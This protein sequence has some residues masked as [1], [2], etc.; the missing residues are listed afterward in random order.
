MKCLGCRAK[1]AV[2]WAFVVTFAALSASRSDAATF[3]IQPLD[4]SGFNTTTATIS[5]SLAN[6]TTLDFVLTLGGIPAQGVNGN[7]TLSVFN[8]SSDQTSFFAFGLTLPGDPES[9]LTGAPFGSPV[10]VGVLSNVTHF[11]VDVTNGDLP[12]LVQLILALSDPISGQPFAGPLDFSVD[13]TRGLVG[14]NAP[15]NVPLPGALLLFA[16]GLGV[17]GL[18]RARRRKGLAAATNE[19]SAA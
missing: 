19:A 12:L 16:S 4:P 3:N 14:A 1:L 11:L 9:T 17:L 5:G 18:A 10:T 6:P 7:V 8:T 15:G 2:A 13:L